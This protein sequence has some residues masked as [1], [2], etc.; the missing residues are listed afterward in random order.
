LKS[1]AKFLLLIFYDIDFMSE[2][3]ITDF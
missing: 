3:L 2:L 1:A